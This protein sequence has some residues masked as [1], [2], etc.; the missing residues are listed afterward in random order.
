VAYETAYGARDLVRFKVAASFRVRFEE[1]FARP[2]R[3]ARA[4]VGSHVVRRGG[5]AEGRGVFYF[6]AAGAP[7][8]ASAAAP[9][10]YGRAVGEL[11][12]IM[13]LAVAATGRAI[14]TA[15]FV[16]HTRPPRGFVYFLILLAAR[17]F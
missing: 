14:E 11:S 16:D 17:S 4:A 2:D 1:E 13:A 12:Q 7:A 6:Q 9:N 3:R 10:R 15:T 8:A 5:K